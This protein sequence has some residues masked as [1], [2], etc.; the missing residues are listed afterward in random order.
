MKLSHYF[1]IMAFTPAFVPAQDTSVSSKLEVYSLE[2]SKRLVIYEEQAHFEAPNWSPD[3]QFFVINQE[4]LLYK[5]SLDGSIKTLID[6]SPLEHCNNDHGISTDGKWLAI[7]NND[8]LQ[9]NT[10]GTSR[11][12]TMPLKGGRPK[13]ITP[14]WPSYWHGWSPDGQTLVYTANRRGDFDIYSININGGKEKRL[15]TAKGLDDGPDYAADGSSIYYNSFQ[16]GTME[17]WRMNSDGTGKEQLTKDRFSN[18]FPHPSPDGQYLVFL[19]YLEDQGDQHPAMK[20]VA[21]RLMDLKTNDIR[22]LCNF[23]GGQ[24][25]INVPSWSPDS[26]KIAFISYQENN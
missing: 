4:G 1:I 3:G 15:T 13:L 9:P 10:H 8:D 5:I 7:S 24:G 25:T 12:Y 22:T 20:D 11:I 14:N 21:L 19:T 16:T 23:T 17:I 26:S 2:S 18:W 6:S